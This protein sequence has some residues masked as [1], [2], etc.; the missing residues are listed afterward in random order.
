MKY[1]KGIKLR[2][3]ILMALLAASLIGGSVTGC[4]SSKSDEAGV[5]N[6]SENQYAVSYE[7]EAAGQ[8]SAEVADYELEQDNASADGDYGFEKSVENYDEAKVS[9]DTKASTKTSEKQ[10]ADSKEQNSVSDGLKKDNK[11]IIKRYN[12]TYETEEFDKAYAYLKQQIEAFD[13][14][15]SSSEITGSQKR[16]LYLTARI[17]ADNS[18]SFVGQLGSLGTMMSQSE[19]AEDITLQYADTESR[20]ASLKTEQERLLALLEKADSLESIITLEDRLTEVRYE[21]ENYESQRKVYDDLVTYSTIIIT[22]EEVTYTV[23]VDDSTFFTRVKTGL[24]KSLRDVRMGLIDFLV[25]LIVALPYL[26][27]WGISIFLIVWIIKKL[28]KRHKRKKQAKQNEK[29]EKLQEEAK[30]QKDLAQ[31][32]MNEKKVEAEEKNE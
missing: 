10:N 19:S 14:Y 8:G 28:V 24:E 5:T 30:I 15:V 27:V 6:Y 11:K 4:G 32:E 26:V 16:S 7:N 22:L 2:N 13:G 29:M 20:I 17:P 23:P 25:G 1:V 9:D 31:N 12:Y 21:L 18:D 3:K